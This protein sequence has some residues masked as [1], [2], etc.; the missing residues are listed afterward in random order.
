MLHSEFKIANPKNLN[1]HTNIRRTIFKSNHVKI[2]TVE[3]F[4][5]TTESVL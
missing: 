5:K 4:L 3:R 2:V 1:I